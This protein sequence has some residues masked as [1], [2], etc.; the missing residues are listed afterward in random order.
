MENYYDA[1]GKNIDEA[2][3][4][5][6]SSLKLERDD[7]TVEILEKPKSGFLGIGASPA[8]IRVFYS[9]S[10]AKKASKFL[11]GL[12]ERMNT[13]ASVEIT[14][15]EEDKTM[16]IVLT[17]SSM[18]V[19]IGKRGDTLDA[20]Q[21]LTNLVVNR[22]E[23]SPVRVI[24]DTENYRARRDQTLDRL[25][26]RTAE[27]VLKIKRSITLEPMNPH[28]RRTVH[29]ALQDVEGITTYSVGVDPF[30][31]IVV[32]PTDKQQGTPSCAGSNQRAGGNNSRPPR[33][34]GG[35]SRKPYGNNARPLYHRPEK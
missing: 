11:S 24:V 5:A 20:I 18:N 4:L 3:A 14:E 29:S 23:D 19:I 15:S 8:R 16:S 12:L 13:P 6:L 33:R 31:K 22:G 21:Y 9:V 34:N 7:V 27:K 25:A 2:I 35:D 26:H 17:G 1:S 10:R 28:E 32:S 30:R